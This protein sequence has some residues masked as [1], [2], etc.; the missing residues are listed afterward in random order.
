MEIGLVPNYQKSLRMVY[1]EAAKEAIDIEGTLEILQFKNHL[2][3]SWLPSWVPNFSAMH[4]DRYPT[5]GPG[6]WR[7][8]SASGGLRQPM[9]RSFRLSNGLG[10]FYAKGKQIDSIERVVDLQG[11]DTHLSDT[12]RAVHHTALHG[13]EPPLQAS[14]EYLYAVNAIWRSLVGNRSA[15]NGLPCDQEYQ[16]IYLLLIDESYSYPTVAKTPPGLSGVHVS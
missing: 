3:C 15:E 10:I 14:S 12:L 4:S 1:C 16:A 11:I 9:D 7:D 2:T 13:K 5:L 8:W 6:A